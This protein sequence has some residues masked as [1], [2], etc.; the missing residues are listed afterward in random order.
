MTFGGVAGSFLNTR[1]VMKYGMGWVIRATYAAMLALSLAVLAAFLLGV[2][3]TL[4]F[5][6]FVLW[7]TGLLGVIGLT[8][9]NLSALA[10]EDMGA[11]AGFASSLMAAFGTMG[12]V[13]LAVPVGQAFDGTA[14][15]LLGGVT[16]FMAAALGLTRWMKKP[17]GAAP[18]RA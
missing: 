12:A 5:G 6:L 4:A 9:G 1:V 7:A 16:L 18:S 2:G 11:M 17:K 8:L 15:P 14:L 13:V 10:M 3:G